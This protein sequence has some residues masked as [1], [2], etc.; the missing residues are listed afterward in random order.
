M[1]LHNFEFARAAFRVGATMKSLDSG[2]VTCDP[3][4]H[5]PTDEPRNNAKSR[6]PRRRDSASPPQCPVPDC[7]DQRHPAVLRQLSLAFA[8]RMHSIGDI[9]AAASA[10]ALAHGGSAMS[11][12]ETAAK[13]VCA[14][15][16]HEKNQ[17]LDAPGHGSTFHHTWSG[18]PA[19]VWDPTGTLTLVPQAADPDTGTAGKAAGAPAE[20]AGPPAKVP[21]AP[22]DVMMCAHPKCY[23][24]AAQT[25]EVKGYCCNKCRKYRPGKSLRVHGPQCCSRHPCHP[26]MSV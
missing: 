6:S 3:A 11:A 7:L 14:R 21:M 13:A 2:N 5:V 24:Q 15:M 22:S 12:A 9:E 18:A 16:Q 26:A 19:R 8:G 20:A 17:P 23:Y 10:A 25:P 4:P 1:L